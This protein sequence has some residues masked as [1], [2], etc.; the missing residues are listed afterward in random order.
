MTERLACCQ[1][2][3]G[4]RKLLSSFQCAGK[5]EG[6]ATTF[7]NSCW[8]DPIS[9]T[10]RVTLSF[11]AILISRRMQNRV[12]TGD[13]VEFRQQTCLGNWA[14]EAGQGKLRRVPLFPAKFLPSAVANNRTRKVAFENHSCSLPGNIRDEGEMVKAIYLKSE[15]KCKM[16]GNHLNSPQGHYGL[17]S[18]T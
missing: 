2:T 5:G 3:H 6:W 8:S 15:C 14:K 17:N 4:H 12:C 1:Q 16:I 13:I 10:V 11:S 7:K 9:M 18:A